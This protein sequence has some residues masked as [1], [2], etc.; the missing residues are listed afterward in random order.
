MQLDRHPLAHL[1]RDRHWSGDDLARLLRDRAA[2]RGLRSGIDRNRIS[3]WERG[4]ATPSEESQSLLAEIFEVPA[5][6]VERLRWPHWLPAFDQPAPFTPEGSRDALREVQI[7]RM[8][9]RSFLVL[10]SSTL[11]DVPLTGPASNHG[12]SI[13]PSMG[14]GP[15]AS[16]WP[17]W[18]SAP[19]SC[20]PWPPARIRRSPASSMLT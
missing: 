20:E 11:I 12:T 10:S 7:T 16:S 5:D 6:T 1:R 13:R 15:I 18:N 14:R 3:L 19:V 17:G 2:R 9:R 4:Y 8:D